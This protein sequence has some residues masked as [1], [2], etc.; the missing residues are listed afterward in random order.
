MPTH[1]VRRGGVPKEYKQEGPVRRRKPYPAKGYVE[2]EEPW[3]IR[4]WCDKWGITEEQ[5]RTAAAA[6]GNLAADVKRELDKLLTFPKQ[7]ADGTDSS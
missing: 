3:E 1:D 7:N 4:Y 6:V 2:F 5:L